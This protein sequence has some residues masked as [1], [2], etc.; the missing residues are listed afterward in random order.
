MK[1][2]KKKKEKRINQESYNGNH[3]QSLTAVEANRF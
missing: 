3:P 1:T 2:K